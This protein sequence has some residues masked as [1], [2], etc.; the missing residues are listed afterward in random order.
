[1]QVFLA[2]FSLIGVESIGCRMAVVSS[3]SVID[4]SCGVVAPEALSASFD[5]LFF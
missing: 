1:M 5:A 3:A 2:P 4:I